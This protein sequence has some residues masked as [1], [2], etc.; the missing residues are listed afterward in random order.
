MSST[1]RSLPSCSPSTS[2]TPASTSRPSTTACSTLERDGVD[3]EVVAQAA[4]PAAHPEGQQRDAGFGA[5]KDYV[6]RLED[7]FARITRRRA[8]A[9]PPSVFDALFAGATAL[10][11][12][13]EQAGQGA[14]RSATSRPETAVL[15]GLLEP[16]ARRRRRAAPGRAR[17]P[18][19]ALAAAPAAARAGGGR[20]TG[21][22]GAARP[23]PRRTPPRART[24][25]AWTSPSS[26]T[27]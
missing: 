25:C 20:G 14:A 15:D 10:R 13:V 8:R 27:C 12:A 4:G 23:T 11:D 24:W 21:R 2:R 17:A 22:A 1:S 26:T 7:V 19:P 6:H 18:R 16:R 9:R 5:I 3:A